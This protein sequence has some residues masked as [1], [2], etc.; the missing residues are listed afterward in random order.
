MENQ[1]VL[2]NIN[3]IKKKITNTLSKLVDT[4][5]KQNKNIDDVK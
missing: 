3:S 4:K 1:K 2:A 5:I